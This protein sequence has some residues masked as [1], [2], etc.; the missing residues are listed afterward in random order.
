MSDTIT[1]SKEEYNDLKRAKLFLCALEAGGV[2][3]W[4]WYSDAYNEFLKKAKEDGL[5]SEEELEEMNDV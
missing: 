2:D 1:I 5:L 3:N 4:D